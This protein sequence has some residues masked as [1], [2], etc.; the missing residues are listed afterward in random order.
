[1]R[2]NNR[3]TIGDKD[4]FDA[5]NYPEIAL[6]MA[7]INNEPVVMPAGTKADIIISFLKDHC[8]KNEWTHEYRELAGV[9][10][11]RAATA[12]TEALFAAC[13]RKALFL[14]DF[15]QYIRSASK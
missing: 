6:E 2:S 8:I 13:R 9:L 11:S 10:S 15:E 1:M 4:V 12:N 7:V 5:A 3:Y 14:N